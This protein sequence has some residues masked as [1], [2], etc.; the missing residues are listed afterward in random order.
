MTWRLITDGHTVPIKFEEL[1]WI[2]VWGHENLKKHN[3]T[4]L[5]II[6][7]EDKNDNNGT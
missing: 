1:D 3:L 6:K 7:E 5:E 4:H 2:F